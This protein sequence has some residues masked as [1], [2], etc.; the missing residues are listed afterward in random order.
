MTFEIHNKKQRTQLEMIL[1]GAISP[2][3]AKTLK[4]T[5]P[6]PTKKNPIHHFGRRFCDSSG[7]YVWGEAALL[8]ASFTKA[9]QKGCL[10][11]KGADLPTAKHFLFLTGGRSE[12]DVFPLP[13]RLF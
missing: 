4:P 2:V 12:K 10:E 9:N 5:K 1:V 7:L 8:R 13:M 11:R 6:T 3:F